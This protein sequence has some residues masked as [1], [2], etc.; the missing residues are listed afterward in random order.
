MKKSI[1][2]SIFLSEEYDSVSG[3][4]N[5]LL[6]QSGV[7]CQLQVLRWEEEWGSIMKWALYK[8]SP[9]LSQV[10]EPLVGDL[11]CMN[12]LR[13]F[14]TQEIKKMGEE[15]A[16]HPVV[17]VSATRTS[18]Q[19]VW[20]IPF[21]CDTYFI[22]YWQDMLQN[23]GVDEKTAF[24]TAEQVENT[25]H[26]LQSKGSATPLVHAT[27]D[28]LNELKHA[29]SWVWGKNGNFIS[30]NQKKTAFNNSEARA[31][32]K[33]YFSLYHYMPQTRRLENAADTQKLFAD[34][35]TAVIL[36]NSMGLIYNILQ[37]AT[38]EIASQLGVSLPPGP[39]LVGSSD[40]VVW[41]TTY[42]PADAVD[43]ICFLTSPSVQAEFCKAMRV[44]PARKG[45]L[46]LPAFADFPFIG[47]FEKALQTGHSFTTLFQG[48]ML[49]NQLSTAMLN[50]WKELVES[51]NQD[52]DALLSCILDPMARRTDNILEEFQ[53]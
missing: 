52:L 31:G 32:W 42:S 4:L 53:K 29:A 17:W 18:A 50:I 43:V 41:N 47:V 49:E 23:A 25:L 39:P 44:L 21:F 33:A 15:D 26:R 5:G 35:Q 24:Q 6:G 13:P 7:S 34:R 19:Q 1:D 38:P 8:D 36:S 30:L 48:G 14:T 28:G 51:P 45:V 40:L 27:N 9:D 22:M 11:I 37:H 16:F 12:A 2:F 3:V 46:S 10:G 20:A